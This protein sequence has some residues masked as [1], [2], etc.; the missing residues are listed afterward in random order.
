MKNSE[1]SRSVCSALQ[2]AETLGAA[3]AIDAAT[4]PASENM[5]DITR[6]VSE[7]TWVV[8]IQLRSPGQ[9]RAEWNERDVRLGYSLPG[10][11]LDLSQVLNSSEASPASLAS[12]VR[13]PAGF[14]WIVPGGDFMNF[15]HLAYKVEP[16]C[17]NCDGH[18]SCFRIT[19]RITPNG[20]IYCRL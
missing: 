4:M 6:M 12:L 3:V 15:I 9:Q 11:L 16:F 17:R 5:G 20:R 8:Y 13:S 18:C 10:V 2:P 1:F 19:H 14:V 7:C